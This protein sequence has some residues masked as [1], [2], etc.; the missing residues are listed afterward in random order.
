MSRHHRVSPREVRLRS[1]RFENLEDRRLLA[2][3][4]VDTNQDVVDFTDGVTSLREA[5]FA[6]NLVGGADEIQFDFGHDGPETIVLTLGELAITDSLTITGPDADLLTIDASGNDPTPDENNGDGSRIFNIDDG[7][8]A[9]SIDVELVGL[10][11][12]GGD[13]EGSGGAI[14]TLENLSVTGSTISGNSAGLRG[15]GIWANS[16]Y[17]TTTITESTISSNSA[18]HD[19]GGIQAAGPMTIIDSTISSNKADNNGGGILANA[20]TTITGSMISENSAGE[21]GGGIRAIRTTTIIDS[22]ISGNSAGRAGGGILS[23]TTTTITGST[24]S[25]NSVGFRGG[26]IFAIRTTTITDSTISGN[27]A[28]NSGGGIW[29]QGRFSNTTITNSTISGNSASLNG[30][31]I[32]AF[33]ARLTT[34][35]NSTI[36]GNSAGEDGGG[37]WAGRTTIIT[38]STISSNKAGNNGGGIWAYNRFSSTTITNST[39]SS[40]K[41]DNNGGGIYID[42]NTAFSAGFGTISHSTIVDNISDADQSGAGAGGGL[43]VARGTLFLEHTIVAQNTDHTSTGRD[44]T[45]V[46]GAI[47][48]VHFSLI[49]DNT[50]SGLA[51]APVGSPDANGNLIG[52]PIHGVID[53][54]LGPLADN[55]RPTLT[56]ALLAGSPAINS[57]DLNAVAGVGGVPL[58]DQRGDGFPRVFSGRIDIGAYELQELSDLN[59]LVDTLDDESDGDFSRFDLSLREAIELANANPV[60]D[61][62]NF[63][64]LLAGGTILLT[65]G[66]LA[67]TDDLA[68][69]GLG[70]EL[71]TIDASGN[72]PTPEENNGDGSRV[73]NIGDGNAA[74]VIDVE[75]RGLTLTG[76]DVSD[77]GGAILS[78]EKLSITSSTFSGNSAGRSGGGIHASGRTTITGSMIS[79]NSAASNGGG[80]WAT[81]S[82]STTITRST[83]SGNSAGDGGGIWVTATTLTITDS[84][85]S[86]NLAGSSGGGIRTGGS[87]TTITNSTISGNSAGYGGGIFANFNTTTI[88]G[89]TISGNSADTDGGG[90]FAFLGF[91]G[92]TIIDSTISG[93]SAGSSGGGILANDSETTIID[94]TISDNSAGDDG[95]G[96]WADDSTTIT[97]STISDK[98]AGDNGGGINVR[99]STTTITNSTI[100]GNSA[101][102]DGGGIWIIFDY[103]G[104]TITGSTI[105]GNSAGEDGGGIWIYTRVSSRSTAKSTTIT[106]STI[107]GNLA[108]DNGGGIW[109]RDA[110]T[111]ITGSTISGNSA[112]SSGG[113]IW[114]NSDFFF[115]TTTITNSTISGNAAN[116]NGG[117]V[118]ID[119][120]TGTIS[121]STIVDNISDADHSG[122][123]SGGGLFVRSGT[124]RVDHT[125]VAQ[126]TDHTRIGPDITGFLGAVLDVH[127]SLIGD[128]TGSGLAEAPVGSP[129][130]QGNL[131]GDPTGVGII[132]PLLGPL[133]DNGGPTQTHSLLTGSPAINAGDPAFV[134]PPDHDQ[135]G[136]PFVRVSGGRI[137]I[138]AFES[139]PLPG[140]FDGDGDSDGDDLAQWEGDYGLNGDSDA[141]GDGQTSGIDFLAWQI[142]FVKP[143]ATPQPLPLVVAS[144]SPTDVRIEPRLVDLALAVGLHET[145]HFSLGHHVVGRRDAVVVDEVFRRTDFIGPPADPANRP[146]ARFSRHLLDS[147]Q[148]TDMSQ[149]LGDALL[150]AQL[151]TE[152]FA[153]L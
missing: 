93:N 37:I 125:I 112:G 71:L 115:A 50:G 9:T 41:A 48:D 145:D 75:L 108:G 82:R 119:V 86:E 76:G 33:D 70:A 99:I 131:I 52:G 35:T 106:N 14:S 10:T 153:L 22:T 34:I 73:F 105:S 113:G 94:S 15:G 149:E 43:Y 31:G 116:N 124:L 1:L 120:G 151:A 57:G 89:S 87:G 72:D 117:G 118:Y 53:P 77:D 111:T 59:L 30:G 92:T 5:I 114:A 136:F 150:E 107:S 36:S 61:T 110:M 81:G 62:I 47:F 132:N 29:I 27:S 67:I 26:G 7:S 19:G 137:D 139:Q 130:A 90:I 18:G 102:N 122:T 58:F 32:Y 109:A 96:I 95:G 128:N 85:I 68:I 88:T 78:R 21:G 98:S 39:I 56:H 42:L 54:L 135:R 8:S 28:D 127:F 40:N 138:G 133:A 91:G 104:T 140:D 20:D 80:I 25:G 69:N 134:G 63:D 65:L 141:D 12:T 49:G 38:D 55:G 13:I 79:E 24:I 129:D 6:T 44:M 4:T 126:N 103:G 60:P 64:P 3:V 17:R 11:L 74:T 84:T 100:S 46:V 101:G 143:A 121:H 2:V 45:G 16:R 66:E 152:S 146:V 51:E 148:S 142:M 23:N 83:I 147:R 144:D 123:G 97:G